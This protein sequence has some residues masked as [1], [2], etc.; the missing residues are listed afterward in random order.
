[1]YED[2]QLWTMFAAAAL[3]GGESAKGAG[4]KA[5]KMLNAFKSRFP[6]HE[7]DDD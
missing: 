6:A 7:S 4:E 3:A 1:M 2:K 5:D